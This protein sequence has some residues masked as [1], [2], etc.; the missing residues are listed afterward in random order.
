MKIPFQYIAQECNV[1]VDQVSIISSLLNNGATVPFIA[2]YRKEVTGNLNEVIVQNIN[3]K[4]LKYN[5]LYKIKEY[6][7]KQLNTNY[8]VQNAVVIAIR[9]SWDINEIEDL[10]L[11]FKKSKESKADLAIKAGLDQ[12]AKKIFINENE[13]S[14]AIIESYRNS[15]FD[16]NEKVREGVVVILSKWISEKKEIRKQL[17]KLL[18]DRAVIISEKRKSVDVDKEIDKLKEKLKK[19]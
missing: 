13:I 12:I 16:T 6:I 15:V 7:L 14:K 8:E 4:L 9:N 19:L 1:S 11:P 2:R 17:R 5:N 18:W 10:Y 3:N